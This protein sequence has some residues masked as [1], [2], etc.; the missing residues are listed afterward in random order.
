MNALTLCN[1]CDI[2]DMHDGCPGGYCAGCCPIGDHKE[3]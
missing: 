1:A 2:D 3:K